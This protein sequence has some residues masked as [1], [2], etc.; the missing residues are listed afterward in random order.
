MSVEERAALLESVGEECINSSEVVPLLTKK[1]D[2]F[3]LYDGFEPSGRMHIAQ[4]V[5][6][7]H[8]VNKCTAAGGTFVFWVADWFA[9]MNDKMGGDLDKIKDVGLY[10][11]EV[12][13]AAGMRMDN[14]E[15]RWAS[16]DITRHAA[17]Y[18][19]LVLD[20]ARRF[21]LARIKKCCQI[22]GRLENSLTAAQIL[23]PLMQC[24]DIFFLK[25]DVCQ[26]G[27]D[28]RKVNMLARDYCDAAGLK[29]KPIILSHHMLYGL[30]A[31][32]AK[33]SK[34]DPDSAIFMEDSAEDVKRKIAQAYCPR[35]VESD[36]KK[37]HD[38]SGFASSS[39]Q[40]GWEELLN[41]CLDYVKHVAFAAQGSTF[42]AGGKTFEN[43]DQV[44]KAFVDG[45]LSESDLKEGL[46]D[47]INVLLDPVRR[48]FSRGDPAA[49]LE[50][51]R[52]YKK[53]D[54]PVV[55][56]KE[57]LEETKRAALR[58]ALGKS[59]EWHPD[60]ARANELELGQNV[61]V[62]MLPAPSPVPPSLG[63][64][65]TVALRIETAHKSGA[66]SVLLY[67]SDWSDIALDCFGGDSKACAASSKLAASAIVGL[68]RKCLGGKAEVKLLRQSDLI[69]ERPS[70][71]WID[72]IHAGRR[73]SLAEVQAAVGQDDST[74][75]RAGPVVAALLTVADLRSS[76]SKTVVVAPSQAECA[77]LKGV[78]VETAQPFS[79]RL[80]PLPEKD[81]PDTDENRDFFLLDAADATKR[82]IKRAFCEPKNVDFNPPL[83]MADFLLT[84]GIVETIVVRRKPENGG[85]YTY[86]DM[87]RLK[88]DFV[89]ESLHPGDLKPA[90][91]DALNATL[92]K[93]MV[94]SVSQCHQS[95]SALA[96][97]KA[98]AKKKKGKK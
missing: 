14:V 65:L 86:S 85:D 16:D 88:R 96:T 45:S 48:H 28:Q 53:S 72:V 32:Q 64:L 11:V 1:P 76:C 41:P 21:T 44:G 63:D 25:A 91:V 57:E 38:A 66:D 3:R 56:E 9:L 59:A 80:Q 30:K 62:V 82:K 67:S 27:V 18:W 70:D 37:L 19:P 15:F 75:N 73:L 17:T 77:L 31:G 94:E 55:K 87:E 23:Y 24:T 26:L 61:A 79:S 84:K 10:L 35:M 43:A 54:S 40:Y 98:F 12:W 22:M 2:S 7:A 92:I 5:F 95:K 68:Y 52:S 49:L 42:V 74:E 97:L 33:M 90:I 78:E 58:R 83:D 13:K 81:I 36:V 93:V 47:A 6:K 20:V 39:N 4:G 29:H 46:A 34:S 8:N 89:D 50:R 71:Y 69:L 51:V 60:F